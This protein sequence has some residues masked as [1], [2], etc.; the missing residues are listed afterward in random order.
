MFSNKM[1][2]RNVLVDFS[3]V[4]LRF[5]HML[6]DL[7]STRRSKDTTDQLSNKLVSLFQFTSAVF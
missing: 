3:G 1:N 5:H 2:V 6:L 7:V 4:V